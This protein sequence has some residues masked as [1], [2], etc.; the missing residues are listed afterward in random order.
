MASPYA[1]EYDISG[2]TDPFLQIRILRLL[3][4]LG[5]G[6][7]DCSDCM[8]DI[9]AQVSCMSLLVKLLLILLHVLLND[10]GDS[11]FVI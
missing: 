6:D 4:M 7:A 8:N 3:R 10:S 11:C 5:Q 2:I 9:L 1:P